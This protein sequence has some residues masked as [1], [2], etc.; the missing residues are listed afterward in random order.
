MEP[1]LNWIDL[2]AQVPT[3]APS[4]A[5]QE[6][7]AI[8]QTLRQILP[9]VL[10]FIVLMFIMGG[11][12]RKAEKQ[13]ALMLSNLKKGDKVETAGGIRGSVTQVD[14]DEITVKV[15]EG[16]NTKLR[17]ARRAIVTVFG[18]ETKTETK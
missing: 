12:K 14:G 17:F 1:V 13:K 7:P 15:D 11:G 5:G 16:S 4:P 10:I 2:L 6:P 8:M 3:S 9:L 18:D